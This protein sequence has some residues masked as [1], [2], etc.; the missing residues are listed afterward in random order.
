MLPFSREFLSW[1]GDAAPRVRGRAGRPWG[2]VSALTEVKTSLSWRELGGPELLPGER[3]VA[4][5][6]LVAG[7]QPILPSQAGSSPSGEQSF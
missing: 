4:L 3:S 7:G 5:K 2:Q 6:T 1:Q